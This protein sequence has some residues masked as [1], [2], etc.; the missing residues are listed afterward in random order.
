MYFVLETVDDGYVLDYQ[1]PYLNRIYAQYRNKPK[2]SKWYKI[3]TALADELSG[4]SL[5]SE[6]HM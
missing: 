6:I 2:A 3:T 5:L 4:L 1:G